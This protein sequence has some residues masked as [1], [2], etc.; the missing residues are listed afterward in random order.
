[1]VVGCAQRQPGRD[2]RQLIGA[3]QRRASTVVV[4]KD[5]LV[6]V[7]AVSGAVVGSVAAHQPDAHGRR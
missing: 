7:L 4:C 2:R 3:R 6:Q 5:G 1:M